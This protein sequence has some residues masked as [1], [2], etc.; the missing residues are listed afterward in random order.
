MNE[1]SDQGTFINRSN[2]EFKD[3][4]SEKYRTYYFSN[5]ETYTIHEPL[6][7]NVSRTGG[8]RIFAKNGKSYYISSGWRM[9]EWEAKPENPNFV[10]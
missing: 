1:K 10:M 9:L 6:K 5:T 4:S 7:L 3:I 2:L 8:H